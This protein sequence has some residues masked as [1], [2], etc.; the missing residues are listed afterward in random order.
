MAGSSTPKQESL[1]PL[2]VGKA[3]DFQEFWTIWMTPP[4]R[5]T[6]NRAGAEKAYKYA[7]KRG[8]SHAEI[9]AGTKAFKN[10][11]DPAC[12]TM[13]MPMAKTWL[14]NDR[15]KDDHPTYEMNVL[16]K[17]LVW[18]G[19]QGYSWNDA[20]RLRKSTLPLDEQE[21]EVLRQW[22]LD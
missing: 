2:P 6:D 7:L 3:G 12:D 18:V 13:Y 17:K 11:W 15:W 5:K 20:L 19:N 8:N 10:S 1:F 9:I 4:R 14:N 16:S 22:N 21:K